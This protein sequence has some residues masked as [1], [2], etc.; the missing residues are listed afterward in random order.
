MESND[1]SPNLTVGLAGRW[2]I[3]RAFLVARLICIGSALGAIGLIAASGG[4]GGSVSAV[5]GILIIDGILTV[6][7]Y[8]LGRAWPTWRRELALAIVSAEVVLISVGEYFLG[9]ENAIYGLPLYAALVTMA[10][11]L[12]SQ[13][14][15]LG[16]ALGCSAGF[17]VVGSLM[18]L[19]WLPEPAGAFETSFYRQWPWS[20]V[21]VNTFTTLGLAAVVG[22]LA[23][24]AARAVT[25][26]ERLESELREINQS[27]EERIDR[28]SAA[29]RAANEA[30]AAKN[31]SL[32]QT[33]R[34]VELFARAVSHDVRNPV[35]A[36]GESI[37][38][39]LAG[40]AGARADLVSLAAENLLRADRMLV[41]LRDLM[42]ATGPR[43]DA[44]PVDVCALVEDVIAEIKSSQ[45]AGSRLTITVSGITSSVWTEPVLLA[46]VFRNLIR[47]A[48]EHNKGRA[49]LEV[50]VGED[51]M[52]G[53]RTFFVR[54][55]GVGIPPAVA[56][57]VFE[58]FRR[59][60]NS[61]GE[62]LGLGLALVE[63]I[64]ANAGGSVW[65][66]R[67][68]LRG[69]AFRFTFPSVPGE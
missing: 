33:L 10:A 67:D 60:L 30:L 50:E 61:D 53:E 25:R 63:G 64:V 19:E 51:A 42:R 4:A 55:N 9:R 44:R 5:V 29:L 23:G 68:W 27:L 69:A 31:E 39:A 21:I 24:E 13:R 12:H 59:G 43:V 56:A 11:I 28:S 17:A 54:D 52:G 20:G 57:R 66:D 41:G 7:Y 40:G 38:L 6:P 16:V 1:L 18:W 35:T 48:V 32:A 58:P 36:A 49:D 22:A 34:R 65:L 62:G 3:F 37:R 2:T 47:N 46:H 15:A 14:A 45:T 8:W 26:S